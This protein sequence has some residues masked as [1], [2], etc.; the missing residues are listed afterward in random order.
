VLSLSVYTKGG[1]VRKQ[2]QART[3]AEA[4]REIEGVVLEEEKRV[5]EISG[6]NPRIPADLSHVL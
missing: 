5:Y 1:R 2:V 3:V 6:V 4:V